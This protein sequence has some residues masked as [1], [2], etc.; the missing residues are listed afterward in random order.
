MGFPVVS[1]EPRAA[2]FDRL[3]ADFGRLPG[4][5]LVRAAVS[6]VRRAGQMLTMYNAADS[7]SL[8]KSAVSSRF[9][10]KLAARETA[11][12]S[13]VPAVSLDHAFR[14]QLGAVGFVK[15]DVR[16][17]PGSPPASVR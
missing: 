8:H 3:H 6:N 10:Q 15:I 7:S 1:F 14:S 16:C 5:H 4:V 13:S 12:V 17:Q 11:K 2:E 9:H